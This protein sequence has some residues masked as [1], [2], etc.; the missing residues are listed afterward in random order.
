VD[1]TILRTLLLTG[2]DEHVSFGMSFESFKQTSRGVTVHF[3]N[4][5]DEEGIL[6]VG[7]DG[8]RSAVRKQYIPTMKILDTRGRCV[9]G[10][11][12]IDEN[13]LGAFLESARGLTLIIDTR[14]PNAASLFMESIR[15]PKTS[16]S[17][18]PP[19]DYLYWA[20]VCQT[21]SLG[22]SDQRFL[23]LSGPEAA[24]H[25]L[26]L[27]ADWDPALRSVLQMQD[28]SQ[29]APLRIST[30]DPE[31]PNWE[32]TRVTLLGDAVHPMPPTGGVGANTA[33]ND[34]QILAE[35][36]QKAVSPENVGHYERR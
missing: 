5:S 11:T 14:G 19:R 24:Q 1:R 21:D 8:K 34:A 32:P 6:L 36:L 9:Y 23:K 27:T 13:R 16:K 17:E 4:G 18:H 15:F 26:E 28:V 7:A 22:M 31:I 12:I 30:T 35:A 33:L 29:T 20:F 10:K 2:L 3:S 25:T